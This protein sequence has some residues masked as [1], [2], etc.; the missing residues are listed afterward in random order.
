MR[1]HDCLRLISALSNHRP[2]LLRGMKVLT[3]RRVVTTPQLH[4]LLRLL[5]I[6]GMPLR[7]SILSLWPDGSKTPTCLLHLH[8]QQTCFGAANCAGILSLPLIK[9]VTAF[10]QIIYLGLAFLFVI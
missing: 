5:K 2:D 4:Q 7:I 6:D 1:A 3:K 9:S 10:I 8:F